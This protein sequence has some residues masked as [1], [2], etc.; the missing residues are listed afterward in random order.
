MKFLEK[1]AFAK[2]VI[3]NVKHFS[4]D[5][6]LTRQEMALGYLKSLAP[7]A[8]VVFGVDAPEH[9][10]EN[11]LCW[12]KKFPSDLILGVKKLF[13]NVDEKILKTLLYGQFKM[14]GSYSTG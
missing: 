4:L 6:G 8:R 13:C 10:K 3:E 5:S 7:R 9:V 12:E 2:P 14:I 11:L 1:M